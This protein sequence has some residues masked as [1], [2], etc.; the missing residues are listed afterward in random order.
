MDS[1]I[2]AQVFQSTKGLEDQCFIQDTKYLK[3][4]L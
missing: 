3:H 4:E 1:E 2:N